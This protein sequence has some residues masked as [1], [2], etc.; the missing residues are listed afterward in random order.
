MLDRQMH[1]ALALAEFG[2]RHQFPD[3][4]ISDRRV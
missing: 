3:E 4:A 2:I 1:L